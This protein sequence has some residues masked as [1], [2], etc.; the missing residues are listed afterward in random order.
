VSAAP[1]WLATIEEDERADLAAVGLQLSP[2]GALD[3]PDAQSAVDA[4]ASQLL[5]VVGGLERDLKRYDD[6]RAAEHKLI[7]AR[8][9]EVTAKLADRKARLES[10]VRQLAAQ[11]DFGGKKS[12]ELAYGTY[13]TRTI[14]DH[15]SI[16]DKKRALSWCRLSAPDL[17]TIK[18]EETIA[19]KKV[20]AHFK[21]TGELPDGCEFTPAHDE[22]FIKLAILQEGAA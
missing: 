22:P 13:G 3:I 21:A 1:A 6:A 18:Q 8:Y 17:L 16:V 14:A 10:W 19:Q 2:E 11:S 5:R 9:A 15:L 7:E 20:E 4:T 12:R